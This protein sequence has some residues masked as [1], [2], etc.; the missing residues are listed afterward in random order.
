VA[1]RT[2]FDDPDLILERARRLA[3]RP[4]VARVQNPIAG[5]EDDLSWQPS[6]N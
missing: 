3:A 5:A 4:I 6:K 1:Q 2:L